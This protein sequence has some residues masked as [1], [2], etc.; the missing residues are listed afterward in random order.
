M[1]REFITDTTNY[2]VSLIL[3][4]FRFL[5]SLLT[6]LLSI[7]IAI[8]ISGTLFGIICLVIIS[9]ILE[10]TTMNEIINGL[11]NQT[12]FVTPESSGVNYIKSILEWMSMTADWSV[13]NIKSIYLENE[14]KILSIIDSIVDVVKERV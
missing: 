10:P 12:G 8:L 14:N 6:S 3:F 1:I 2:V 4:P 7:V 11:V 5:L 9:Y 13:E